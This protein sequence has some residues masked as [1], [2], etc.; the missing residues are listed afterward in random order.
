M[1]SPAGSGASG[2]SGGGL[3]QSVRAIDVAALVIPCG[4]REHQQAV[5][6]CG[7]FVRHCNHLLPQ[8]SGANKEANKHIAVLGTMVSAD[9]CHCICRKT[10]SCKAA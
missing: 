8:Y 1:I 10:R 7:V 2:P 3:R 5:R 9:V 6:G 4:Q